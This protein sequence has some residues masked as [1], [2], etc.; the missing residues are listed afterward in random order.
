MVDRVMC[1]AGKAGLHY[2][3]DSRIIFRCCETIKLEK[4]HRS[5]VQQTQNRHAR[6]CAIC[7]F[8]PAK[9]DHNGDENEYGV[10]ALRHRHISNRKTDRMVLWVVMHVDLPP[11]AAQRPM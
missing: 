3:T 2:P 10:G 4:L 8:Q 7:E 9:T 6:D 11:Q 5:P 1:G